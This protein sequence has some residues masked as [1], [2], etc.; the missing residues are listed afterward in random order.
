LLAFTFLS[1]HLSREPF[2]LMLVSTDCP[3][4]RL[5]LYEL[6]VQCCGAKDNEEKL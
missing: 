5:F 1:R 6:A 3:Q 4:L 2:V